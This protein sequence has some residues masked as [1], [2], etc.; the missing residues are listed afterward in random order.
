VD[1][2]NVVSTLIE[3]NKYSSAELKK[4]CVSFLIKNF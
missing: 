4:Y 1:N 3:A 2:E